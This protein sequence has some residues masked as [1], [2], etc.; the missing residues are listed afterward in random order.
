MENIEYIDSIAIGDF[1]KI[2]KKIKDI[3]NIYLCNITD[4]V[5]NI[6][7]NTSFFT[8]KNVFLRRNVEESIQDIIK[9][10]ERIKILWTLT[11]STI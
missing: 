5:I 2:Y 9:Q 4:K 8:L 3:K 1:L 7:Y 10:K 11:E 6:L